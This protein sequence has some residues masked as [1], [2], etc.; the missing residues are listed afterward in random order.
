MSNFDLAALIE[1]HDPVEFLRDVW[2]R[3]PLH[4]AR[5]CPNYHDGLLTLADIDELIAFTR[6]RFS[7]PALAP[8]GEAREKTYVKGWPV[9]C[10]PPGPVAFPG[11]A[12][13]RGV[14]RRGKTVVIM[15]MQRRRASVA[16]LCRSLEGV[17]HCPVHANLYLTP[18]KAQGFDAHFDP[19]EVF[20]L[21]L[22]GSKT[23]RLYGPG[24]EAPLVDEHLE[25][26]RSQFGPVR[27]VH[28]AAGDLLYLPRGHIHEAFTSDVA[29]L[30]L[31]VGVN[32]YRWVD[33]LHEA[34][35]ATARRDA[36]LRA[37]LP[38]GSLGGE[39]P[40]AMAERFA[41]L[42]S[43][44]AEGAP[45][46]EALARLGDRFFG[47]LSLLPGSHF[48]HSDDEEEIGP[49]MILEKAPG[50]ICRVVQEGGWV[51]IEFPGGRLGGPLKIAGALRLAARAD[52]LAP[53][54]LPNELGDEG[55]LI[56]AR[57]LVRE[58]LFR[59]AGTGETG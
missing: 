35:D 2:E 46:A 10:E 14:Y 42:L 12:E 24:R 32:V 18:P 33:L 4:V 40:S 48:A 22:A 51:A 29:S 41:S 28:L 37:S 36:R 25:I 54:D 56:L 52:R 23:W 55:K 3:R 11:I 20:V 47:E 19:H 5:G 17:F 58:G 34:L 39:A 7:D 49:E 27:E 8:A 6:P 45:F 31:T 26:P 59:V 1:P 38:P 15:G 9:D 16:A 44:V 50:M 30:H 13:L 43:A 53:R 57:R 21:Q